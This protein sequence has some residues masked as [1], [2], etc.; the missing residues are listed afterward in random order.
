MRRTKSHQPVL[1]VPPH[2][3]VLDWTTGQSCWS[4]CTCIYLHSDRTTHGS[5][6]SNT[7]C[8]DVVLGMKQTLNLWETLNPKQCLKTNDRFRAKQ[9]RL[10][11]CVY[12]IIRPH[13]MHWVQRCS[14]LLQ[15][16]YI[17]PACLSLPD[18][19]LHL[20]HCRNLRAPQELTKFHVIRKQT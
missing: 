13:R 5:D 18:V 4:P 10:L 2:P 17:R 16:L 19:K 6:S 1:P 14:L 12:Y 20:R 3:G 9:G 11:T 15:M 8:I 7:Q